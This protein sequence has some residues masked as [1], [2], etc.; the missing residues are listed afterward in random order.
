MKLSHHYSKNSLYISFLTLVLGSVLYF[1]VIEF[2]AKEQV[3][4]NLEMQL[5]EA[6]EFLNTGNE[7]PQRYD[8]DK[9]HAIFYLINDKQNVSKRFFDTIY[10]NPF[11]KKIEPGRA[12]ESSLKGN[13]H[14]YKV[15]IAISRTGS[16]AF[17]KMILIVTIMLL[18]LLVFLLFITNKYLL[19]G[20]WRS[21]YKI[22]NEIKYLSLDDSRKFTAYKT[23]VDEF[24]E[25]NEVISNMS[26]KNRKDYL[27]LK[28]FTEN[29]SHEMMTPL[30]VITTKLD[31]LI[32]GINLQSEQLELISEIYSS[33]N[34]S[35]RLNQ[36]LIL[37]AK[38][39]NN[40]HPDNE[41]IAVDE[42]LSLKIDQVKDL[43][44]EKNLS[45]NKM[46]EMVEICAN[47]YLIDLVLNN[48]LTNAI[49]HNI[50]SGIINVR[51]TNGILSIENTG[52]KEALQQDIIYN[53]FQKSR[54]S[55]GM[56]L[57]LT[58]IKNICEHY[59]YPLSYNYNGEC[60]RF[61][62]KLA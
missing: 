27:A 11:N 59:N 46:V 16:L 51:L 50:D 6:Y 26:A 35:S 39:E 3:D 28:H 34:K 30:A 13:G 61:S 23:D 45:L 38:I 48:L 31:Q 10:V 20:L 9:D 42:M 53:R 58:L 55:Q 7:D 14:N 18:M 60:H 37:L 2:I 25:L 41:L 19:A 33:V 29:A 17:I 57:G 56:G 4:Q 12:V 52:L 36:T 47:K 22:L 40:L 15:V 44:K 8:L 24:K 5:R 1:F 62:I 43:I 54:S 21:F 32:Q 49:W